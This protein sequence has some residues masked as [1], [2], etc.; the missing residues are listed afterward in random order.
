MST[1]TLKMIALIF[2]TI[3]HIG[4]FI[5]GTPIAFRWVGRIS[6]PIF[7]FCTVYGFNYTSNKELY[8]KRLYYFSMSMGIVR[9]CLNTFTESIYQTIHNNFFHTLFCIVFFLYILEL[10]ESR[11]KKLILQFYFLWQL[12]TVVYF[13]RSSLL[14]WND[15]L[16]K[17][18][19]APITGSLYG[20]EGGILFFLLGLIIY[21]TKNNKRQLIFFYL[22]FALIVNI[23]ELTNIIVRIRYR[24]DRFHQL[25]EYYVEF[26]ENVVNINAV[27]FRQITPHYSFNFDYQWMMI[28]AIPFFLLYNHQKGHGYKYFFFFYPLHIVFLFVAGNVFL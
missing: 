13:M 8:L 2:M 16:I 23:I 1:T 17:E 18:V 5:P 14:Y 20:V 10:K 25:S 22:S 24:I 27:W 15:S 4:V 21:F 12:I 26:F 9:Y 6:A 3:D 11:S 7:L 19:I 28:A